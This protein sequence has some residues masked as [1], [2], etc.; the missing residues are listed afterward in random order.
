MRREN[1]VM[2]IYKVWLFYM[3]FGMSGV[4]KYSRGMDEW[5]Y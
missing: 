3:L 2:I 4:S 5:L 1:E